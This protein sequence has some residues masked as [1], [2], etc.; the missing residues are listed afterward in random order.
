MLRGSPV[1]ELVKSMRGRAATVLFVS[2]C[3]PLRGGKINSKQLFIPQV[4]GWLAEPQQLRA[5]AYVWTLWN[6][7]QF[8]TTK[9]SLCR[10]AA[11]SSGPAA[12]VHGGC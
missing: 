3:L 11:G 1:S 6:R 10:V 7:L 5:E 9:P 8:F 2:D 4:A 12:S